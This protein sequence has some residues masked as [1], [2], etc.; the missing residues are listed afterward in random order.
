MIVCGGFLTE[1]G[2]SDGKSSN[3]HLGSLNSLGS[4]S[5]ELI[6]KA[7]STLF[8]MQTLATSQGLPPLVLNPKWLLS[9]GKC[10]LL[11]N[12]YLIHRRKYMEARA[13]VLNLIRLL[14]SDQFNNDDDLSGDLLFVLTPL[15][16]AAKELLIIIAYSQSRN[17]DAVRLIDSTI[18]ETIALLNG[19]YYRKL[20]LIRAKINYKLGHLK[21]A[22]KDCD[23]CLKSFDNNHIQ[24]SLL[25]IRCLVLKC[26][27]IQ[28]QQLYD[29]SLSVMKLNF[30]ERIIIL[31]HAKEINEKLVELVGGFEA[32]SNVTFMRLE[33]MAMAHDMFPPL[34]HNLTNRHSNE[35]AFSIK[36]TFDQKKLK[37]LGIVIPDPPTPQ[38]IQA[39][40][41]DVNA[42]SVSSPMA[43]PM[44]NEFG[45]PSGVLLESPS[46]IHDFT[47]RQT[48]EDVQQ[49]VPELAS[50]RLGPIDNDEFSLV[51]LEYC[52]VYLQETRSIIIIYNALASVLDDARNSGLFD[53]D[54]NVDLSNKSS[55][56]SLS[57]L[58]LDLD[59][60]K[61]NFDSKQLLIQQIIMSESGLKIMRHSIF[62]PSNVR[63]SM[64]LNAG[65]ARIARSI[66]YPQ[67]A[68][69]T[70]E[71]IEPLTTALDIAAKSSHPWD[72]MRTVCITLA[73]LYGNGDLPLDHL[74]KDVRLLTAVGFASTAVKISAQQ[75]RLLKQPI[76]L[77]DDSSLSTVP[78]EE[79]TNIM[80]NTT[81]SSATLPLTPELAQAP[82]DSATTTGKAPAKGKAPP[83]AATIPATN[84]SQ[85]G[86]NGRDALFLISTLVRERDPLWTDSPEHD[87]VADLHV[88]LAR[89]YPI[90]I[91]KCTVTA[92][93][94][95]APSTSTTVNGNEINIP[96]N[97]VSTLWQPVRPPSDYL[98]LIKAF[99]DNSETRVPAKGSFAH[100]SAYFLL[101][102]YLIPRTDS[103]A[104]AVP[105]KKGA[106]PATGTSSVVTPSNSASPVLTKLVLP[107]SDIA[108]IKDMIGKVNDEFIEATKIL[109]P[110]RLRRACE[111]LKPAVLLLST[112]LKTGMLPFLVPTPE[113]SDGLNEFLVGQSESPVNSTC[114]VKEITATPGLYEL[115]FC[116]DQKPV[117]V[118]PITPSF[119]SNFRSVLDLNAESESVQDS[120]LCLLLRRCLGH[121]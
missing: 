56:Q 19:E 14:Q 98:D 88:L 22:L 31:N 114:E 24:K 13:S 101:G 120:N 96:V 90:Y 70:K 117:L 107:R 86:P 20:V 63:V 46:H 45:S 36:P 8:E 89:A 49:D 16:F 12:K 11:Q 2:M 116:V 1:V 110:L 7:T 105:A 87:L 83:P 97:S 21:E 68:V 39:S 77:A 28:D 26:S 66:G 82:V 32:D 53:Y 109:F 59:D 81:S 85:S 108:Y 40:N 74:S 94:T 42:M 48:N 73:E 43:S 102:D 18:Q 6:Y 119:I 75:R 100:V 60:V 44:K 38:L 118:I 9:Y 5:S 62:V 112:L 103:S 91:Q 34:L 57:R 121:D 4:S 78:I 23:L 84:S 35:P 15:Y 17:D 93:T 3:K 52:N 29:P 37:Q 79:L 71:M 41:N 104:A 47:M 58:G 115:H 64:L 111:E 106:P 92:Q 10:Q 61:T 113:G 69:S 54:M 33:S 80:I 55:Y 51:S 99:E 95:A 50:L 65:R 27:I 30:I 76:S 67:H 25:L 72:L